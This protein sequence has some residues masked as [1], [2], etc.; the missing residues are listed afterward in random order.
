MTCPYCG[1]EQPHVDANGSPVE[2]EKFDPF[3]GSHKYR[4]ELVT[5]DEAE[6]N[7]PVPT[8]PSEP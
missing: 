3:A 2:C 1:S 8:D 6:D 7:W 4:V 5:P